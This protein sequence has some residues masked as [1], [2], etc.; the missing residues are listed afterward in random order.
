MAPRRYSAC[1]SSRMKAPG[2]PSGLT[3]GFWLRVMNELKNRAVDDILLA[4]V[5]D[6]KGFLDVITA[7]G[8][9]LRVH[10]RFLLRLTPRDGRS[11][12]HRP[13]AA[14]LNGLCFLEG[15]QGPGECAQGHLPRRRCRSAEKALTAFDAG[16]WGQRYP[17]IGQS[18]RRAWSEVIS[19][20]TFPDE[21]GRI[22]YTTNAIEALNS[23]LRRTS[24]QGATSPATMPPPS[25]SI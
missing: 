14:Q 4:V 15:P 17:A 13:P 9:K 23:K 18:W 12:L 19:F 3:R 1:G 8:G 11:N 5:D 25:C 20:F 6:L 22:V 16:F 10:P 24:G 21:V 7:F 2:L